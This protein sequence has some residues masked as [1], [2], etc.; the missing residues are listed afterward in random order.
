MPITQKG[1]VEISRRL[2]NIDNFQKWAKEPVTKSVDVVHKQAE[3]YA[4]P[5]PGSRY[6]R[7][8][9]L[10]DSMETAVRA[11]HNGVMG[12]VF[13]SG[14]R[15]PHGG[16]YEKYVKVAGSQMPFHALNGW[17]TDEQDLAAKQKDID[18]FWDDAVGAVIRS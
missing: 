16:F 8:G 3:T 12:V 7:T 6:I 15:S 14:A 5:V 9:E 18:G 2:G 1:D 11:S 17:K 4:P 10:G 13:S